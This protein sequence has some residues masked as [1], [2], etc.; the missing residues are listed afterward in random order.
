MNRFIAVE[1][2]FSAKLTP[3]VSLPFSKN[4]NGGEN[5]ASLP[6]I[7]FFG[8]LGRQEGILH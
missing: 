1:V 2:V 4:E 8:T 5:Q 7:L 6:Q 3:S